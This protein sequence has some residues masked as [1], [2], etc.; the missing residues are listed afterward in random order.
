MLIIEGDK[1]IDMTF[2]DKDKE[3]FITDIEVMK[4]LLNI[5]WVFIEI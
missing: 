5:I 1:M 4:N 3:Y 2:L